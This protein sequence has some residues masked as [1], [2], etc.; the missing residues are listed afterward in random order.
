MEKR[1]LGQG[2][3]VSALGMGCMGLSH[4]VGAPMTID[5]AAKVVRSAVDLGYT[6]FD[7][8]KNYGFK[9]DPCHN[10]KIL[11]KALSRVR[12]QVVISTKTGVEFDYDVDPDQPPL[13]YDSSRENIR[14]SIE[15]SLMRLNTDY[16]DIYFQA[17]IDPQVEPEEVAETMA[18]LIRE[19]KILHWGI[20][21]APADY[22][23]RAHAVC[24]I[25]AVENSYSIINRSHEDLIPFLE[26]EGIGWI[27]HGPV[28]KGLL[29]GVFK[30][31]TAFRRDDWRGRI[32]NDEN[33]DR[34]DELV[35][36]LVQLGEEK[37]ATAGQLAIAWVLAQRP[38]IVPIP[39]MRSTERLRENAGAVSVTFTQEELVHI[40]A[41]Y[42]K[43]QA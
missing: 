7:T 34:Y 36:Y 26:H 8:A 25:A 30:K 21:E 9:D 2:L 17:R 29:T 42:K 41:L 1:M 19:G 43:A 16:V 32:V 40:D 15:A 20:S 33:I 39:G 10:E 22:I 12:D 37:D 14:R 31:G 13:L 27:A 35:T 23:A 5:D 24:P 6:F 3:T 11:G 4:A 38:Y 28:S 18:E